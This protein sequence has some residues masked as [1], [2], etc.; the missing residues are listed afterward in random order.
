M[1]SLPHTLLFL[2]TNP[3][4][5]SYP[6]YFMGP[7]CSKR[8]ILKV[9]HRTSSILCNLAF[10]CSFS[11]YFLSVLPL[12]NV[13]TPTTPN[14]LQF[15]STPCILFLGFVLAVVPAWNALSTPLPTLLENCYLSFRTQALIDH[16]W[17]QRSQPSHLPPHQLDLPII[18]P[19]CKHW[20]TASHI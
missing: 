6:K 4:R 11:T 7:Y 3:N 5:L 17:P 20:V 8:K 12:L 1:V 15:P 10:T 19:S 14:Y 16:L 13:F 18:S 2:T 9:Q